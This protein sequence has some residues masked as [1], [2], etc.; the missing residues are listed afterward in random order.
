MSK[1]RGAVG[2]RVIGNHIA[3]DVVVDRD[4]CCRDI[5]IAWTRDR[6]LRLNNRRR[7]S[8]CVLQ[9]VRRRNRENW[10]EDRRCCHGRRHGIADVV[11][12][13]TIIDGERDCRTDRVEITTC[14]GIGYGTEC[15]LPVC[16]GRGTRGGRQIQQ[17]VRVARN[18]DIA[19]RQTIVNEPELVFAS[20]VICDRHCCIRQRPIIGILN[21]D[22]RINCN[23]SVSFGVRRKCVDG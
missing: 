13:M 18:G 11:D 6:D 8:F 21:D 14:I 1:D 12:S 3:D 7:C 23:R 9:R 22:P 19:H 15:C 2:V 5:D 17:P 16:D 10:R 4:R 20:D